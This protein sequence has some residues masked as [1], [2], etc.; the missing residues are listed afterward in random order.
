M[1]ISARTAILFN[2]A[3]ALIVVSAVGAVVRGWIYTAKSVPCD[4][5]YRSV[6]LM[7][8]EKDG[9]PLTAADLQARSG[10]RDIG[11]LDNVEIGRMPGA[12]ARVAMK[13]NLPKGSIAP[14]SGDLRIGGMSFPWEPRAVRAQSAV[15]LSYSV[16]LST[17][18]DM[19]QNGVLPGIVGRNDAVD[20]ERFAVHVAWFNT[21]ESG[22]VHKIQTKSEQP[23]ASDAATT[24][25]A[26]KPAPNFEFEAKTF[27]LPKG[28]WARINQEL[29]LNK[30]GASD[31]VLRIWVD[32][33]LAL[34][35]T[36]MRF[37][38]DPGTTVAGVTAA[39][40]LMNQDITGPAPVESNIWFT[41]YELRWQ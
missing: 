30:P 26:E 9:E 28:R 22:V 33:R 38:T 35:R 16:M 14:E 20:D 7:P 36:D 31:G 15:C 13:V 39:A 8:L 10:G 21:N 3:A 40:H 32:G 4:Q 18:F 2:A 25:P 23:A 1:A 27:D 6:M 34:E 24:P 29:V 5:R 17:D 41:P 12:P 11:L 37:R 19:S